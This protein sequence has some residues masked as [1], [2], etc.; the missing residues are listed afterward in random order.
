M[1]Q[2][3]A[4]TRSRDKSTEEFELF[5]F[6][7]VWVGISCHEHVDGFQ[8]CAVVVISFDDFDFNHGSHEIFQ[9]SYSLWV[10]IAFTITIPVWYATVTH[11]R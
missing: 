11:N 9:P 7:R 6:G 1:W 2:E 10:P 5:S 8:R 4:S 3:N